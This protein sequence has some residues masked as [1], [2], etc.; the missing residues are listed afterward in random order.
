MA[1]RLRISVRDTTPDRRPEIPAPGIADA[2][3]VVCKPGAGIPEPGSV[4]VAGEAPALEEL[5]WLDAFVRGFGGG[6]MVEGVRS[7]VGGPE[8]AG[9][10]DST[11]HIL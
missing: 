11:I 1:K 9:E 2:D 7:G 4:A 8:D 5:L 10:G 6:T 3:I